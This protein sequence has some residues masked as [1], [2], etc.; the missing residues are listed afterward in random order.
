MKIHSLYNL[1]LFVLDNSWVIWSPSSLRWELGLLDIRLKISKLNQ[2]T[3]KKIFSDT[4]SDECP[5]KTIQN[6]PMPNKITKKIV[7]NKRLSC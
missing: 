6:Y 3:N 5:R 7:F 2:T 4:F 1:I